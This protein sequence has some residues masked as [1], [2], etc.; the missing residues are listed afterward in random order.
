MKDIYKHKPEVWDA[1]KCLKLSR[2][3]ATDGMGTPY[4]FKGYIGSSASR[5]TKY[6]TETY[7]G[8]CICDDKWYRGEFFPFPKLAKG[9]KIEHVSTWGWR[10]VKIKP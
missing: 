8:G 2:H 1:T 9:F 5:P 3:V 6:G 7:N 10:I 4:P